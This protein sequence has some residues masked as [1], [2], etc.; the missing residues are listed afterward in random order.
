MS[1]RLRGARAGGGVSKVR[2]RQRVSDEEDRVLGPVG[3]RAE[4]AG[5]PARDLATVLAAFRRVERPR[6]QA[7]SRYTT[8]EP[9]SNSP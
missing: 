4:A 7:H 2:E 9:P 3:K 5:V 6:A 1:I 8:I